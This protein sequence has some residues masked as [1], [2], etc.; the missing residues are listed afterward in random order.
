MAVN[1]PNAGSDTPPLRARRRIRQALREFAAVPLLVILLFLI[2]AVASILIDQSHIDLLVTMRHGLEH[3]VGRQAA[4]NTLQAIAT[5]LITVTSI[6]FSVLLLAVQQTASTLSPMVFDQFMRRRSNQAYFGVFL[7]LSL[8]AYV[9]LVAVRKNTPPVLGAG[10]ATL[11]TAAALVCL[12]MLVY[13]TVDQ[14]RPA[15]VL[16]QIHDRALLGRRHEQD[17]IRH[18]RR[19]EQSRHPVSATY[20]AKTTG[21]AV[22]ID[23]NRLAAAL[24]QIPSAEIR[25]W[26][27][28]AIRWLSAIK[29][30]L[31]AT[32]TPT[33]HAGSPTRSGRRSSSIASRMS[34]WMPAPASP[35]SATSRGRVR[36]R[37]NRIRRS[38]CGRCTCC[39]I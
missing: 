9:V 23:L 10:L 28:L 34:T 27:P 4:T 16:R 13:S 30:R 20:H 8:Y 21:Y 18:T 15:N 5:G 38:L 29:W 26:I 12:L 3:F 2:L 35:R 11:L 14:M 1:Q 37:P 17:L 24:D 7:G 6:T 39:V 33:T 25:L 32:T 22:G 19:E 31:C 36:R